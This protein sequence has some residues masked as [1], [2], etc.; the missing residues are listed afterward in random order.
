MHID[1][2]NSG[3]ICMSVFICLY[4]LSVYISATFVCLLKSRQ[5]LPVCLNLG[6]ICLFKCRQHLPVC[7]N[8]GYVCLFKFRQHLPVWVS[9]CGSHLP[10]FSEGAALTFPCFKS[11]GITRTSCMM[12]TATQTSYGLLEK[13]GGGKGRTSAEVPVL[14]TH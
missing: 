4:C 6:N 5:H 7:L 2:F 9:Q 1:E 12:F 13:E 11:R 3:N 14:P 8:L 10:L